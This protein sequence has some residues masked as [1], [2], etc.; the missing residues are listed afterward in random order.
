MRKLFYITVL[1][2]I[3]Y[4]TFG[5]ENESN[6]GDPNQTV[7]DSL[8]RL[9]NTDVPDST[10]AALYSEI[11][12]CYYLIGQSMFQQTDTLDFKVIDYL[13][14]TISIFESIDTDDTYYIQAKYLAYNAL[15]EAFIKAARLSKSFA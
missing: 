5:Q 7:I 10:R 11:A 4:A 2:L 9:A 6:A 3:S 13:K 14:K 1:L 8:L 15:A 12:N